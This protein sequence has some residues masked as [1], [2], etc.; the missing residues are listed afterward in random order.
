M[1]Q[2]QFF[3]QNSI[4]RKREIER[5]DRLLHDKLFHMKSNIN[6][7]VPHSFVHSSNTAKRDYIEYDKNH[8]I[9]SENKILQQKLNKIATR[10]KKTIQG[11]H[12]FNFTNRPISQNITNRKTKQTKIELENQQILQRIQNQKPSFRIRS[13]NKLKISDIQSIS[14]GPKNLNDTTNNSIFNHGNSRLSKIQSQQRQ[15]SPNSRKKSGIGKSTCVGRQS[16]SFHHI[17]G[18]N[19]NLFRDDSNNCSNTRDKIVGT[20]TVRSISE[21]S[22]RNNRLKDQLNQK[23]Y[24]KR[25]VYSGA[26]KIGDEFYKVVIEENIEDE[27]YQISYTNHKD[28]KLEIQKAFDVQIWQDILENYA[29]NFEMLIKGIHEMSMKNKF[30][31]N[32]KRDVE[33]Q[34]Y[35]FYESDGFQDVIEEKPEFHVNNTTEDLQEE[36]KPSEQNLNLCNN[37]DAEVEHRQVIDEDDPFSKFDRDFEEQNQK[38]IAQEFK[39]ND[40]TT[41]GEEA[42]QLYKADNNENH[43]ISEDKG[44]VKEDNDHMRNTA[45][46]Q[47]LLESLREKTSGMDD[48]NSSHSD[49]SFKDE[50]MD[51]NIADQQNNFN[52]KEKPEGTGAIEDDKNLEKNNTENPQKNGF[53]N[54]FS[55][56]FDESAQNNDSDFYID[57]NCNYQRI[58]P[59]DNNFETENDQADFDHKNKFDHSDLFQNEET[60]DQNRKE[61]DDWDRTVSDKRDPIYEES[62]DFAM[63]NPQNNMKLT[64]SEGFF[65]KTS[66]QINFNQSQYKPDQDTKESKKAMNVNSL[67]GYAPNPG[68]DDVFDKFDKDYQQK[69]E[70]ENTKNPQSV[71]IE[72]SMKA[73]KSRPDNN[74]YRSMSK[75]KNV[76]DKRLTKIDEVSKSSKIFDSNS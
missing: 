75:N 60:Q 11:N 8:K 7:N 17:R 10:N 41:D 69:L 15:R 43:K 76:S 13:G 73:K 34:E 20:Q 24:E 59:M 9:L 14:K 40:K 55:N 65:K 48:D 26:L 5:N 46:C 44:D 27:C 3:A 52:K 57:K 49:E 37:G 51:S 74:P 16:K 72:S 45:R 61:S 62:D 70:Q 28:M 66:Q 19:L 12:T 21:C 47:N 2:A 71:S 1:K 56:D 58:T 30:R 33:N 4:L 64:E 29:N 67:E 39:K 23:N 6:S 36:N 42:K 38:E 18:P 53:S 35:D 63:N 25:A 22:K 32:Q 50:P 68:Y 54:I 31:E